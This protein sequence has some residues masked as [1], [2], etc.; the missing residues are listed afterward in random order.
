MR[1]ALIAPQRRVED[2]FRRSSDHL[3]AKS[4][5]NI[6]NFAFVEALWSHLSP[7]VEIFPWEASPSLLRERCDIIVMACANQLGPHSNLEQ[8]ATTFER[9]GLPILAIGLGAQAKA[10]GETIELTKGTERWL[11]VVA[12]HAPSKAPNIGVRGE[13][14]REQVE[15][16]GFGDRA[17]VVGCPSHFLN[18]DPSLPA[19]LEDRHR[20]EPIERV[21]VPAGLPQWAKLAPIERALADIVEATKGIYIAQSEIDMVRLARGEWQA[22]APSTFSAMR[23]Y[24]RP[25]VS[26][27]AFRLWCKRYATCFADATSWMESMRTFDFVV[28]PR[29]HGVMLAIQAGTPGAVIA[30]DSRTHEL[31]QTMEIPVRMYHDLPAKFSPSDLPGL[32]PF[33]TAAYAR[34]RAEL[35]ARY[36]GILVAAGV[37]PSEWLLGLGAKAKPLP[38]AALQRIPEAAAAL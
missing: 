2:A 22:I 23:D 30:H 33:E 35:A 10:L 32:F 18:P 12:A 27:E 11:E 15:R 26:G 36:A 38:A 7:H 37:E 20:R 3:F 28:G 6:G 4:G 21:A 5:A 34:K 31:C 9:A 13:F 8:L 14:S 17:V 25:G 24:I 16:C 19:L 29:F 1:V